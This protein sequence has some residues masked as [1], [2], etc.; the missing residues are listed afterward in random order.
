[1][2][3]K[4]T[5]KDLTLGSIVNQYANVFFHIEDKETFITIKA[6]KVILALRSP[7][8]QRLFQLSE[9][10]EPFHLCVRGVSKFTI[11][12]A[13]RIM[14]GEAIQVPENH[15]NRVVAYLKSIEIEFE[16]SESYH[17]ESPPIKKPKQST[18]KMKRKLDNTE[19]LKCGRFDEDHADADGL[20]KDGPSNSH[21]EVDNE[22]NSEA[23]SSKS[24]KITNRKGEVATLD[25]WTETSDDIDVDA[26]DFKIGET[27]SKGK[28][29]N[30]VCR[31]CGTIVQSFCTA[32]FHFINQHQKCDAELEIVQEAI[33]FK[34]DAFDKIKRLQ[35][36]I[37]DGCNQMLGVSQLETLLHNLQERVDSLQSLNE[38][39]LSPNLK[40]KKDKLIQ[41]I[42]VIIKRVKSFINEYD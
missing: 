18:E 23:S 11:D 40:T 14:Y 12:Y 9:K 38:K 6:N 32:Q 29:R 28:H 39:N 8:L 37:R 10:W 1:M 2:E 36:E 13:I 17:E 34:Q 33:K 41:S 24:V 25:N 20:I 15:A 21:T 19:N 7:Y 4:L 35:S 30:Y 22:L 3:L 42:D 31:H 26:I 5:N 16:S 27:R